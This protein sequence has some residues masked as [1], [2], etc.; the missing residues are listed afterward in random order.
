MF[1]DV[2]G[3]E[4]RESEKKNQMK[5][6]KAAKRKKQKRRIQKRVVHAAGGLLWRESER[7]KELAVVHRPY[8]DDWVLPKGKLNRRED[9][10]EAAPGRLV[11]DDPMRVAAA[12]A[13]NPQSPH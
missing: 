4:Q 5:E 3:Q 2:D 6:V 10:A 12:A 9:W 13:S 11:A 8:Y 1:M 7:G